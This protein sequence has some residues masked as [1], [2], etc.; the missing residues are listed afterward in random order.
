MC[1]RVEARD[2]FGRVRA[3][4]GLATVILDSLETLL[5]AGT[6]TLRPVDIDLG[7]V[8]AE[9][10]EAMELTRGESKHRIEIED[11]PVVHADEGQVR[12][13]FKLLLSAEKHWRKITAPH[14][15]ALVQAGVKFPDGQQHPLM[16][17]G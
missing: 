2:W 8:L 1:L 12:L 7:A 11:L 6:R 17:E 14:L 9:V 3:A 13:A 16:E 5:D 4:T 10:A 15:V